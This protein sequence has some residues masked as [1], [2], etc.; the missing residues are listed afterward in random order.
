VINA[1]DS[2]HTV[3]LGVQ[4]AFPTPDFGHPISK[5]ARLSFFPAHHVSKSMG[6]HGTLLSRLTS[7][8]FVEPGNVNIGTCTEYKCVFVCVCVREREYKCVVHV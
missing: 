7:A 6:M 5:A 2:D 3:S 1:H 4:V 8:L